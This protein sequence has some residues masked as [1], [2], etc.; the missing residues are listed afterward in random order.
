[1]AD[2]SVSK[3]YSIEG[4]KLVRK[5]PFCP[6]CGKGTFLSMHKNRK[7]CGKCGYSEIISK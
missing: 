2:F 3:L 4:N 1:M 5:N 6:K 7:S